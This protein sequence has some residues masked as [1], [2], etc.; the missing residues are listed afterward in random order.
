MLEGAVP[1]MHVRSI[2]QHSSICLESSDTF[3]P[4]EGVTALSP[5]VLSTAL[6]SYA[7][8]A[9][10]CLLPERCLV[11]SGK[12]SALLLTP[13]LQVFHLFL[14]ELLQPPGLVAQEQRWSAQTCSRSSM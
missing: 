13:A 1:G 7:T 11:Q 10:K 8:D 6:F 2:W 9:K 12:V 14:A 4:G 3:L 5:E